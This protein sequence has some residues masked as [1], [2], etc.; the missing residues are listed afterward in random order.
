MEDDDDDREGRIARNLFRTDSESVDDDDD[1]APLETEEAVGCPDIAMTIV[2]RVLHVELEERTVGGSIEHRL[3]PAAEYLAKFVLQQLVESS[4]SPKSTEPAEPV[5]PEIIAGNDDLGKIVA[6]QSLRSILQRSTCLR[7]RDGANSADP[8]LKIL[9]L[10]A[11]VGLTGLELA[12]QL[13]N[14]QVLLTDLGSA[15]PLLRSNVERNQRQF[16]TN[17]TNNN[18]VSNAVQVQKLEW[19]NIDDIDKAIAWCRSSDDDSPL[20]ILGSDCVYWESLF[21]PLEATIAALL[22]RAVPGSVCLLAG[23]R[24]WKRDNHFY[25]HILGR[26]SATE[27]GRLERSCVDEHVTR[28]V[29]SQGRQ[30]MRIYAVQWIAK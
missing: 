14:V 5:V 23:M 1:S 2:R 15:L 26:S 12:S 9:E 22:Q 30:V 16:A 8:P 11:G 25:Q 3:W 24:R 4:S 7:N 18:A 29:G 19:G 28:V 20:L 6:L 13:T 21:Q 27:T 17:V 10:G